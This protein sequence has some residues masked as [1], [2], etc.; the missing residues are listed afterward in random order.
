MPAPTNSEIAYQQSGLLD[1]WTLFTTQ[2]RDWLGGVATGGPNGDGAYPLQDV[3]GQ[4]FLVPCPAANSAKVTSLIDPLTGLQFTVNNSV[5]AAQAAQAAAE[6]ANT[7][8]LTYRDA[9]IA[10]SADSSTYA[11]N[12]ANSAASAL[13]FKNAASGSAT[14]ASNSAT[15]AASSA[16]AASTSA[17]AASAS[18]IAADSS[19]QSAD[20]DAA[21]AAQSAQSAANY[22]AQAAQS[23]AGKLTWFGV[24]NVT[25]G[26]LPAAPASPGFYWVSG[27]ATIASDQYNSGDALVWGTEGTWHHIDN[28][29]SVVSVAGLTGPISVSS[30]QT[31]LMLG[32]AAY[33]PSTAFATAAQGAKADTAVQ[34]AGSITGNAGTATKLATARTIAGVSFDGSANIAVYYANLTGLPVLGT[35]AAQPSTAFATAAQGATA[36]AAMPKAG[37]TFTGT[38]G[39]PSFAGTGSIA[40]GTGDAATRT[41]HNVRFR[42]WWGI[43]FSDNSDTVHG[44]YDA[45]TGTWDVDGG[46][47]VN[48]NP[49]QYRANGTD[50]NAA[51]GTFSTTLSSGTSAN[52]PLDWCTCI[53]L[54]G[55]G[56]R[57]GQF[58]WS[59]NGSYWGLWF[60]SWSDSGVWQPW[61]RVVLGVGGASQIFVQS[62][63]PGSSANDG[64]LWVW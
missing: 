19:K 39:L 9:A 11:T 16:T 22:A 2:L 59:Y 54:P 1:R 63:D 36:D 23:A 21:A 64:D 45:R 18:A 4:T 48:G 52:R 30:L 17:T 13:T 20:S 35:A 44:V 25:G 27:S 61:A 28:T 40:A 60:R 58:A 46:Y 55:Y 29:Q 31:A 42:S 62:A 41:V 50:L 12:S 7:I 49:I 33:Q 6:Q 38:I 37:G 10:A 5:T 47:K 57:D 15:A 53:N 32:T 26:T 24:W 34:P 3:T 51:Q 43:G 8:G 56:G 14:A